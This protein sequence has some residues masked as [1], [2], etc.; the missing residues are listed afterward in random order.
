MY[1]KWMIDINIKSKTLHLPEGCIEAYFCVLQLGKDISRYD[2]KST[3]Y[4]ITNQ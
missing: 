2:T 3:I 1:S 4:K